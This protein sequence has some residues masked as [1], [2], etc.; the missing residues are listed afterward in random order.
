M[1]VVETIQ[2]ASGALREHRLRAG[3]SMLGIA[4][5]IGAV[6]LLTSI[7]EGARG[8]VVGEL[9]QF[10]TNILQVTPGKTETFGLPGAMGGTTRKL[11]I[12]DAEA[13][14]RVPGVENVV[15]MVLGQ[16]RVAAG[17]RGRSVYVYGVS[18][19][20]PDVWKFSV[21]QGSFLPPGD[22][23]RGAPVCVLG[24][25]LKRELFG[26]ENAIGRFVRISG[27][28]LRVLGVMEPKGL[29]LGFDMDDC[30]YVPVA[31]A[32]G[33]FD[34]DALDEI[35]V[36]FTS[37]RGA[38]AVVQGITDVLRERHAGHEDFT[39]LTQAAMLEVFD[40]VLSMV[41]AGV[42]AIA[43][44]SLLVGVIGILTILWIAV[45]E[46]THEIGL[47]RALGATVA[48]VR[49]LFLL[50]AAVLSALGGVLGILGG[51]G[52]AQLLA[53]LLPELPVSV[54]LPY[55]VAALVVSVSTGLLAGLAPA[56]RA[57]ALD[58][59]EALRHE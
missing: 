21:V 52:L 5:G 29:I 13:L 8:F 51:L 42:V 6:I 15:P 22:P 56:R 18:G 53:L 41:T 58:P 20:A 23:R 9:Q 28:R 3:L 57:A 48:Q 40:D 54:P 26:E 25:K 2:F 10:G 33:M 55:A 47:L 1:K 4:I 12:D 44:I 7:G 59:I 19:E 46:R 35:N 11:T 36:T 39:V 14:R 50:E 32:M 43:G 17:G 16:A 31:T 49:T 27:W 37:G 24:P 34:V 45:G 30:A 38:P